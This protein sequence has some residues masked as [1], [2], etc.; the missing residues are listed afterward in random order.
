[1]LLH[2]TQDGSSKQ[3]RLFTFLDGG[4]APYSI[5]IFHAALKIIYFMKFNEMHSQKYQ[6]QLLKFFEFQLEK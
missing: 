6:K 4:F 3:W 2:I 5:Q 1:M